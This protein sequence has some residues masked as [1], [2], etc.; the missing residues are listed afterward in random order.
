MVETGFTE[1]VAFE[2]SLEGLTKS[3]R[4][5]LG[6]RGFSSML[7]AVMRSLRHAVGLGRG[8]TEAWVW[9]IVLWITRAT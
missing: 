8:E 4:R 7:P 3:R 5:Q 6:L 9:L 1:D 2:P